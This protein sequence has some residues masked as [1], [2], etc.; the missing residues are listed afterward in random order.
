[1]NTL[2]AKTFSA[3]V[4]L[5]RIR[6]S[7]I[8]LLVVTS[9]HFFAL[10]AVLYT[11]FPHWLWLIP[12]AFIFVF[13]CCFISHWREQPVYRIQK[14]GDA[15][16]LVDDSKTGETCKI[17]IVQ[18]YYWSRYLLIWILARDRQRIYFPIL[19]DCCSKEEFRHLKV[20]SKIEL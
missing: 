18:C 17:E 19:P 12:S 5:V 13:L 15:W 16:A 14:R 8:L 6:A 10:I 3:G 2:V 9:L 4:T 20:L 11:N 7:R 1:M